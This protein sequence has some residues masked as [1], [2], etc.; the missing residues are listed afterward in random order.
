MKVVALDP[1]VSG[2]L[3]A[4]EGG[5]V[6]AL[7]DLPVHLIAA[8]GRGLRA[9]LDVP[10]LHA[11]LA[12]LTPVDHVFI[13][14][15]GPM[16]KQ[17]I[18]SSWRFAEAFGATKAVVLTMGTPLTLVAPKAWQRFHGIGP[19]SDEARQRAVQLYPDAIDQLRRRRD[20]HRADALLIA[21]YGRLQLGSTQQ[22]AA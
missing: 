20:N 18:V 11:L 16:P 6:I 14:R 3:A 9:E 7:V 21:D 2:A 13:E 19:A 5:T 22:A 8:R 17:G 12:E 15:V 1:G 10:G 4:L